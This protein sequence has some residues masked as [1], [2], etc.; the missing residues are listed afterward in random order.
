MT[1]GIVSCT[2]TLVLQVAVFP[3]PSVTLH[4]EVVVPTG[5]SA[6]DPEHDGAP[7]FGQLSVAVAVTVAI[8]PAGDV[9]WTVCAAGQVIVGGCL[10]TTVIDALQADTSSGAAV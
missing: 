2:V 7:R 4:S 1:G 9:H 10:S 3:E 6:P 5:K 8:A